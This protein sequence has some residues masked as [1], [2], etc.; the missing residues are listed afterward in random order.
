MDVKISRTLVGTFS[1]GRHYF[2]QTT[3]LMIWRIFCGQDFKQAAL[4]IQNSH[5]PEDE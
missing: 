1:N 3:F 4:F 5:F 2:P